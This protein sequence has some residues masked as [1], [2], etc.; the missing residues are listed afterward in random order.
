MWLSATMLHPQ[1]LE[2]LKWLEEFNDK[3]FFE[4]YKPLYL[5]IKEQF[6]NLVSFLIENISKFDKNI[7]WVETKKCTFR[8]Y[9]DMRFPRNREKPYKINLWANIAYGG[10]KSS[11]AWYYIHIQNQQSYFSGWVFFVQPKTANSI[12]KYIYKNWK[13]FKKII[14]NPEFK[15][16]FGEVFSYHPKLKKIP[17]DFDP[18]HPSIKYILHRDWLI[19]K[20]LSNKEVLW[21]NIDKKMLE[22]AKIAKP[23]NQFL[24]DAIQAKL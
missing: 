5:Q 14:E 3:K 8:I 12:R 6:E 2:F 9:K 1:T 19:N 10:K 17:K 7:I 16:T 13:K 20:K 18:N 22:Y 4:L 23:F 11:Y 15:K 24:N 21:K